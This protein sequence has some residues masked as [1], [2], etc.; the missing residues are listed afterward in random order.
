MGFVPTFYF[1][2]MSTKKQ[3]AESRLGEIAEEIAT[4][5][6]MMLV[7]WEIVG[8]S[9]QRTV[10]VFIDKEGGITHDDC[11]A[12]S[13]E[14]ETILDKEDPFAS[15]YVLEVSSPGLERRLRGVADFQNFSGEQAKIKTYAAIDGQK[16]FRGV[17]VGVEGE[18]I[19]FDDRSSGR[20]TIPVA[21]VAKANLEIDI[22]E[23]LKKGK[24]RLSG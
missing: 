24:A 10:R 3:L 11:V 13:R 21:S 15:S 5:Q 1:G 20:V 9:K 8:S 4:G 7:D 17:I 12:V 23:E 16:N 19:I 18:D 14:L 22:E 6:G 2:L